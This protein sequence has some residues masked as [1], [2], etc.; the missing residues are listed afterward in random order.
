MLWQS[1]FH[2]QQRQGPSS[3]HTR[4]THTRARTHAQEPKP[5]T[6]GADPFEEFKKVFERFASAEEVTGTAEPKE[7][8]EVSGRCVC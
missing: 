7:D 5:Q 1:P 3:S 8:D 6:S 2:K 4:P